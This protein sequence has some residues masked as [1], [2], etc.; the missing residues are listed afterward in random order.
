MRFPRRAGDVNIEAPFVRI[1]S[2]LKCAAAA[3][4]RFL[5]G[6]SSSRIG[7]AGGRAI[8]LAATLCSA[9]QETQKPLPKTFVVQSSASQAT[10]IASP[11]EA[12]VELS[13]ALSAQATV[14]CAE[15]ADSSCRMNVHSPWVAQLR[16]TAAVTRTVLSRV[17]I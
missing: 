10:I 14:V 6:R 17:G 8:V 2:S 9:S 7:S 3:S 13:P 16:A 4:C 15:R 5:S 12:V 1:P 11:A